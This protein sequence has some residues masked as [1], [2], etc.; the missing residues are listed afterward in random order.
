MRNPLAVEK[1]ARAVGLQVWPSFVERACCDKK[2]IFLNGGWRGGKSA[3]AAFIVFIEILLTYL[4]REG[5]QLIWLVGPDYTQARQEYF[6]LQGWATR[7]GMTVTASTASMGPLTM[8]IS[9]A[10]MPGVIEVATKQ[11]GDPT[12]LGSVAP[13]MILACEAGQISEEAYMWLLGR[14]AEKN[15]TLIWS[16]T[17][18]NEDQKAQFTWFEE[19]SE[20]AWTAP[21]TR[22][23]AFR[24]PTWENLSLYD[25]C[26][27]MIQDDPSLAV[28]CPS[29]EHGS[30]HSGLSHPMIRK[31][32]DQWR[33]KPTD[34]LKRFGGE[35]QA[36]RNLVYEWARA[37][38]LTDFSRNKYLIPMPKELKQPGYRWLRSAGGMDFGTVHPSAACVGSMTQTGD[39]WV[40]R[41][42]QDRS[43]R[44]DWI[45]HMQTELS[46]IYHIPPGMWGRDPM[47]KYTPS[48][49][50]GETMSGSL[51]AREARVGI[52]NSIAES[53]HLFFDADQPEVVVLFGQIQRIHRKRQA[54]GQLAYVR[55]DD[56]GPAAWEDK[57]A[58]L[59]GQPVLNLPKKWSVPKRRR[60]YAMQ[61]SAKG[62]F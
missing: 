14:T 30:S 35:P 21:T 53:G 42:P 40:R 62:I 37:D 47:V 19:A 57:M 46:R 48:Y 49:V 7:L 38:S 9:A 2:E 58:M 18:E 32:Q 59:H 28:W 36:G 61:E 31:L 10:G 27:S 16:G 1:I 23:S 4:H 15:A 39:T 43:G 3:S 11:A 52:C 24:L 54:N 50:P 17:F 56:D 55:E 41:C 34:W 13:V 44:M 45:W 25:S 22:Q 12:S 51:F 29:S 20:K 26:L 6:Y 5:N 60:S 33:D 8:E